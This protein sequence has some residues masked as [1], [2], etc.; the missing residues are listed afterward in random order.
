MSVKLRW[1]TAT[2]MLPAITHLVALSVPVM[3]ALREMESTAQVSL[4]KVVPSGCEGSE[5]W[6]QSWYRYV[7]QTARLCSISSKPHMHASPSTVHWSTWLITSLIVWDALFIILA[8]MLVTRPLAIAVYSSVNRC[9]WMW[10]GH[11][12]LSCECH[13]CWCD[14]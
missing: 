10:T 8:F 9:W 5:N 13:L 2:W 4:I 14:W 7:S 11:R 6:P 3:L 1:T 12:R